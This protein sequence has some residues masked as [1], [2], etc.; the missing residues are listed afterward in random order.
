MINVIHWLEYSVYNLND[1]SNLQL[2][3]ERWNLKLKPLI[4]LHEMMMFVANAPSLIYI[5][6]TATAAAA[7]VANA[8]YTPYTVH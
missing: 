7:A 4:N 3:Y 6:V 1:H 2:M 5:V 8:L